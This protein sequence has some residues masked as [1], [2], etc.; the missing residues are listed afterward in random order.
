MKMVECHQFHLVQ[1]NTKQFGKLIFVSKTWK[2]TS[3]S[4][5]KGH[6]NQKVEGLHPGTQATVIY[7]ARAVLSVVH[8]GTR[9]ASHVGVSR[10]GFPTL[11][12]S[13]GHGNPMLRGGAWPLGPSSS[14]QPQQQPPG[15]RRGNRVG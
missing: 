12:P 15:P 8:A 1:H 11:D 5:R 10:A 2:K 4:H 7:A 9:G 6:F 13:W 3:I 14:S